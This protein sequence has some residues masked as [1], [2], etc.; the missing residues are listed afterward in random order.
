MQEYVLSKAYATNLLEKAVW[1][2]I[3]V[4]IQLSFQ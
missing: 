3:Y 4:F 1:I 2:D